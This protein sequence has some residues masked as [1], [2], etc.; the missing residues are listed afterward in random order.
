MRIWRK[1]YRTAILISLAIISLLVLSSIIVAGY[2]NNWLWTGVPTKT[3]WDWLELLIIPIVLA[4]SAALFS[5]AERR[6]EQSIARQQSQE[7]ILEAY[8][9]RMS[10]LLFDKELH[11]SS[12][13]K[14]VRSV[15]RIWTLTALR[16]L[17]EN[18]KG[19]VLQFLQEANLIKGSGAGPIIDLSGADLAGANLSKAALFDAVLAGINLHGANLA[20]ADLMRTDLGGANLS[21][22]NLQGAHMFDT[23]LNSANLTKANLRNAHLVEADLSNTNLDKADLSGANLA[24]AAISPER[25]VHSKSLQGATMPNGTKYSKNSEGQT[26]IKSA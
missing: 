18:R 11:E 3:L 23:N 16:R 24:Q 7:A 8:L 2:L 25:L 21:N 15:A 1:K 6:N 10:G 4:I 26:T 12:T 14:R 5:Q 19:V 22:T 17:D 20:G 13:D 9:E